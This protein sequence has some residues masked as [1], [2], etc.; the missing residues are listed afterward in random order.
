MFICVSD[1]KPFGFSCDCSTLWM[2]LRR[3]SWRRSAP[4]SAPAKCSSKCPK[5]FLATSFFCKH[6]CCF[7][8]YLTEPRICT[9]WC[10]NFVCERDC[11]LLEFCYKRIII[12]KINNFVGS[13]PHWFIYFTVIWTSKFFLLLFDEGHSWQWDVLKTYARLV[14]KQRCHTHHRKPSHLIFHV[15]TKI[16]KL[17]CLMKLVKI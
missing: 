12:L 2:N 11:K 7:V 6:E 8:D 4:L 9:Q 3:T 10:F 5:G 1:W 17:T 16:C 13:P 14:S 15:V